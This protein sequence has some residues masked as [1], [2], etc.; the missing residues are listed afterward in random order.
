MSAC[1]DTRAA[2]AGALSLDEVDGMHLAHAARCE[3]CGELLARHRAL[4]EVTARARRSLE[5]ATLAPSS[6]V[7][8]RQGV[9]DASARRPRAWLRALLPVAAAALAVAIAVSVWPAPTEPAE[10]HDARALAQI[11]QR[12]AAWPSPPTFEAA[13]VA[14]VEVEVATVDGVARGV[15]AGDLLS[16]T[17]SAARVTAFGRHTMTL[18]VGAVVLVRSWDERL[19]ELELLDGEVTSEVTRAHEAERFV[20][21]SGDVTVAVLGTV[22]SVARG[23]GTTTVAVTRGRVAVEGPAGASEVAAGESEVFRDAD[24]VSADASAAG[25]EARERRSPRRGPRVIDIEVPAQ[26]MPAGPTEPAWDLER[27]LESIE[28]AIDAGRCEAAMNALNTLMERAPAAARATYEVAAL[29][30]R[31]DARR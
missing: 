14:E 15:A 19:V 28:E 23:D 16:A 4:A 17:G 9:D 6:W 8:I 21:A 27:S 11:A 22:F 25:G 24:A 29:R 5:G 20:V 26:A 12:D 7:R 18:S 10:R 1:A 3:A 13:E 31:C 2:F 30:A